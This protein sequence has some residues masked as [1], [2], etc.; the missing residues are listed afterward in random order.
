MFFNVSMEGNSED[1][2]ILIFEYLFLE[3]IEGR[4]VW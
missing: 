1:N 4:I 2:K 3:Y